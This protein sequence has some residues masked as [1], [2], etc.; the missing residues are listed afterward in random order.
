M[1]TIPGVEMDESIRNGYRES[2]AG[3]RKGDTAKELALVC[4]YI[5]SARK[6]IVP[7]QND[8][9]VA[10]INEVLEEYGLCRAIHLHCETRCCDLTRMPAVTKALMALDT[11]SCNLVIARGRLGV[12]GSGS[13]LV[14]LDAKGRILTAGLSPSHVIHKKTVSESVRDEMVM[15]LERIGLT[16]PARTRMP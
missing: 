3:I 6:I 12:P 11:T 16:R 8:V 4:Q 5:R 9:K 1:T 14:F 15:A 10:A 7:N 2:L 13:M